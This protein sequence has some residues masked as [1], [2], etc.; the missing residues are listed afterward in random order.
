MADKLTYVQVAKFGV[1]NSFDAKYKTSLPSLMLKAAEK[2]IEKAG[3]TS[4]EPKDKKAG[5]FYLDGNLNSLE[6][7][8]KG[9]ECLL[10]A[11]IKMQ[12]AT[13]PDKSMFGFP[14]ATSKY[15]VDKP[16]KI[17]ADV[18]TL[19]REMIGSLI[20]EQVVGAIKQRT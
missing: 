7:I 3:F 2:A 17:D 9:K 11:T 5:G 12:L 4:A 19:V 8:E 15:P 14:S 13:W 10:K 20:K 1:T 16:D 6:K 18:E